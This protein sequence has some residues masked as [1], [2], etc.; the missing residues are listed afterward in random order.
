MLRYIVGLIF[1]SAICMAAQAQEKIFSGYFDI[2]TGSPQGTE[3]T[4]KVHLERNKDVHSSPIPRTY[5]FEIAKQPDGLFK[6]QTAFDPAGRI[7]G[8]LST[9]Q[10]INTTGNRLL[11]LQLKDG[12]KLL[13]EFPVTVKM[14]KETLWQTLFNRYKEVTLTGASGR[15]YGRKKPKDAEVASTIEELEAGKGTFTGFGFYGTKPQDYKPRGKSIE[16]DW[17]AVCN[18]I[19]GLGYA[20][21]TSATYGPQGDAAGRERL[22]RALYS[23]IIAYTEAVPVEGS[24]VI[25]DGKPI[26][27]CTGDG[28][29]N[30][31]LHNL[32]ENQV[33]THQWVISDGLIVPLVHL[34][35]DMLADIKKGDQ[36]ATRVYYDVVRM[37]QTTMAEVANRRAIDDPGER[38]GKLT[39]TL[40]SSG[41]WADAN[42]GHRSRM[43]LALPIIWADYN[44]PQTYVQYWYSDYYHDK[45]F[46]NF[47]FSP[48]WSPHGVVFDVARWLTK[49]NVPAHQY[50]QSGFQ[51]DGTVSHHIGE[52]TDAA[53]VAYGFE[54]LTDC[55]V[56]FNQFKNT[57]FKLG[58]QY[59]Q[60]PAD[61]L[62]RVY[63]KIIYNNR[64]DF[65][66][67]GRSFDSD[68]KKFVSNTYLS[69]IKELKSSESDDTRISNQAAL[70]K[71]YKQIKTGMHQYNG[72]DVYWINEY[73][74]HR[75]GEN[76]KPFYASL[77]LKSKRT[78]SAEDFNKVRR[79]WYTGYGIMPV[80]V[81]GDEYSDKVLADMDW[82][83]LPGLTEEW[84]T[85]AMPQ[86]HAAL[87]SHGN[88]DLA[89]VTA[90]G[91]TGMGIYHHLPL[92][93]YSSAAAHKTYHFI[94]DKSISLGS[95][96]YRLRPGQ[97]KDIITTVDQS[98][99]L[100]T[101]TVFHDGKTEV[102]TPGQP[103]NII[104][105]TKGP[106]WLHTG[107]KGYIIYPQGKQS[108]IIKTGTVI[109]T[110]DKAHAN[111]GANYIIAISHGV[112]PTKAN[113]GSYYYMIVPNVT[114]VDM[115]AL[116][117]EY[118]QQISYKNEADVHAV[119]DAKA[120]TWQAGFFKPG[121][122]TLNNIT[123]SAD[124]P[125][126]IMIRED[127]AS[128]K[129]TM[130][131]PVPVITK[132][133]IVFHLSIALKPGTYDYTL[134]GIYPRK[135]K[136]VWV[137]KEGSGS[138]ITVAL[139]NEADEAD[140]SYQAV[141]YN[142]AP[143]SILVGK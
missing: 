42:L 26:G 56:G 75:R 25:I 106:V 9:T 2:A 87:A 28:F 41:A 27:N 34:M 24:D 10:K 68:L 46:K 118:A 105:E 135:G 18:R 128:Y 140:F 112:N 120:E 97:G 92:E 67:S 88:N 19:G 64:F 12:P 69:A 94:G 101:L 132:K 96:I 136:T 72:T 31:K 37:L 38:W 98:A 70:D 48:G 30:L 63:P 20:Y 91:V 7:T 44:R 76:E 117:K 8:V 5:H 93:T 83:A 50:V 100:K 81:T 110:T 6:I 53:M 104:F 4:G 133:Q 85:D 35:P 82:H 107:E 134:G 109:N 77:K 116:T 122:I 43:M 13:N 141:L 39:D 55:L 3:V 142:A 71:V 103:V 84:R 99:L 29:A 115:P 74:V 114:A 124:D 11:T 54:W 61:R 23:A 65:L 40:R 138:K 143:V 127:G 126:E 80:K 33:V 108:I 95:Q 130:N 62:E 111:G 59:Y 21:A 90:D 113:A 57:G 79:S 66:V 86:G 129:I 137:E 22:K 102:I 139:V 60:F 58:D 36:Q 1:I 16:Y 15:M 121:T 49:Y 123:V 17:E 52:G 125:S 78:V 119:Y 14:V 45:P 89:G 73:L 32:I 51:P 47:S 131:N